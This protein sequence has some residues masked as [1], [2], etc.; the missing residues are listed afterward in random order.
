[1]VNKQP[2]A[3]GICDSCGAQLVQRKD[4]APE[5]VADRLKVYHDQTEPLKGYYDSKGKLSTVEGI[6]AVAEITARVLKALED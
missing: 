1:I 5:T 6:G 4:D 3:E 2:K